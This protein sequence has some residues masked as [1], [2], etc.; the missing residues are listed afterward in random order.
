MT[1]NWA[2]R[3]AVVNGRRRNRVVTVFVGAAIVCGVVCVGT[4]PAYA[5]A[6]P[7]SGMTTAIEPNE[8]MIDGCVTQESPLLR[9][10]AQDVLVDIAAVLL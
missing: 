9:V 1:R 4:A 3:P 8:W 6:A 2:K 5:A 7:R 10:F